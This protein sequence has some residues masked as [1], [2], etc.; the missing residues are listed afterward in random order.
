MGRC[1]REQEREEVRGEGG[2]EGRGYEEGVREYRGVW[3]GRD[4][5]VIGELG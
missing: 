3:E 1:E 5:E 2:G 4:G